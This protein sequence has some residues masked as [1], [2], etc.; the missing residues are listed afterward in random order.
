MTKNLKGNLS[1][2]IGALLLFAA[3]AGLFFHESPASAQAP[4]GGQAMPV[5]VTIAEKKPLRI[6]TSFSGRLRAVDF[7][8]IRPE[9]SG[10][11]D[12]IKFEDGQT[13]NKGDTLL[14]IDPRPY[15]ASVEQAQAAVNGARNQY[16]LAQKELKRAQDLIKTDAISQR[17]FDERQNTAKVTQNLVEAAQAQLDKA[18]IDLDHAYVKAPISGR[19]SRAEVTVGNLV[20]PGPGAPVLTTIVSDDG[21]YADFEVDEQTYLQSIRRFAKDMQAE[22]SI[23]VKLYTKSSDGTVYEGRIRSFDNRIDPSSGT[24]RA[25]AFFSNEN[26]ALLPGMFVTVKMGSPAAEDAILITEQA[27]GTDQDRKFV[28]VVEDGKVVYHEVRLGAAI[29]GQRI[30]ESGLE[31]GDQVIIEGLIKIR[32]DMPVA[33]QIAGLEGQDGEAEQPLIPGE[34]PEMTQENQ[35]ETGQEKPAE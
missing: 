12:E 29:D 28:Y 35:D 18:K 1:L 34:P 23:P 3:G 20:Q 13:V 17:S 5:K 8:E 22:T 26:G 9:V 32:P 21:I 31:P 11:I 24:I 25:R 2:L 16:S 27:I 30:I 19:V 33:P 7:V 15:Q 10:R 14:V 4:G 6:W